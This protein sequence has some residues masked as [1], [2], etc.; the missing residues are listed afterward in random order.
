MKTI[1]SWDKGEHCFWEGEGRGE[2]WRKQEIIQQR[3]WG[4][5]LVTL[6]YSTISLKILYSQNA[7]TGSTWS[8]DQGAPWPPVCGRTWNLLLSSL[9]I[10]LDKQTPW[11]AFHLQRHLNK[12]ARV[13]RNRW[14]MFISSTG[15]SWAHPLS[16]LGNSGLAA[17]C[18]ATS[19][20]SPASRSPPG[21]L[22]VFL[23]NRLWYAS[24]GKSPFLPSSLFYIYFLRKWSQLV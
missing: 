23:Q 8:P 21:Q 9:S 10:S 22:Q 16:R 4:D 5:I 3:L 7:H 20:P 17:S 13:H 6:R 11:A 15:C 19:Q 18:P 2:W 1:F 12:D 24:S 14:Q